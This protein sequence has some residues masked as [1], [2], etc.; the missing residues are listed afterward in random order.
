MK[1]EYNIAT[2]FDF[3]LELLGLYWDLE[4]IFGEEYVQQEDVKDMFH[5]FGADKMLFAQIWDTINYH[6]M[7]NCDDEEVYY[8]KSGDETPYFEC[9]RRTRM[10]EK[11]CKYA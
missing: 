7:E 6:V 2:P 10:E 5:S 3:D 1:D 11:G 4:R 9:L 8:D